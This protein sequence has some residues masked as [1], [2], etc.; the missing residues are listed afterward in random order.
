MAVGGLGGSGDKACVGFG[1]QKAKYAEHSASTVCNS[2]VNG[3][4]IIAR[5]FVCLFMAMTAGKTRGVESQPLYCSHLVFVC[6]LWDGGAGPGGLSVPRLSTDALSR[7]PFP[8]TAAVRP[9]TPNKKKGAGLRST[10]NVLLSMD[11]RKIKIKIHRIQGGYAVWSGRGD[12]ISIYVC[13]L[14]YMQMRDRRLFGMQHLPVV[15]HWRRSRF[16]P[17]TVAN[18]IYIFN[19]YCAGIAYITAPMLILA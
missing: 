1:R 3:K 17:I 13:A 4:Q 2:L 5:L 18:W 19:I 10:A 15:C 7:A 16:I 8:Q 9:E 6:A 14:H 12:Y 11:D